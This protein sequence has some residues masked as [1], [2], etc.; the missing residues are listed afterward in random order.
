MAENGI[1][2]QGLSFI[3]DVRAI[4]DHGRKMAYAA[5]SQAAI[6]TYWNVG[7]RIVE[8]EQEGKARAEYGKSLMKNL[9]DNL[10]PSY[11]NI[12]SKRNLDYY[13]KFYL[14]FP[15]IQIVNARVHNLEW[16]QVRRVLPTEEELRRE[17]EQQKRFFLEQKEKNRKK[18]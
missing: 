15:D 12:F 1:T 3:S 18:I 11:G 10:V 16:T 13:K 17:I 8:E 4:I 2:Q 5:A 14:L 7:R 9:A 6:A